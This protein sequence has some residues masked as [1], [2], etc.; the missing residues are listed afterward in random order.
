MRMSCSS[1]L[2][3]AS[4]MAFCGSRMNSVRASTSLASST[5]YSLSR[6]IGSPL[7]GCSSLPVC[8]FGFLA[9]G[10]APH[11]VD[12]RDSRL[13]AGTNGAADAAPKA[14]ER[15]GP[16]SPCGRSRSATEDHDHGRELDHGREIQRRRLPALSPRD[17]DQSQD[18][19]GCDD[20]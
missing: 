18:H 12:I 4:F 3:A 19:R 14:G 13:A 5:M 9:I 11:V 1:W 2:S 8:S 6:L 15:G 16:H 10:C 7:T 17:D 20:L